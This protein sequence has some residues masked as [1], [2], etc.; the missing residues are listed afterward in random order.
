MDKRNF[1][2]PV[3]SV[4]KGDYVEFCHWFNQYESI[5]RQHQIAIWGA[6]IRGTEFAIFL[7]KKD[8]YDIVFVDS[9]SEKWGGTI[10]EFLII[11]PDELFNSDP[12]IKRKILIS[13]E[14][15]REIERKLE[16]KGLLNNEDFFVI[17]TFLYDKYMDEFKRQYMCKNLIMGDCE[18]S[19]I[20]IGDMDYRTLGEMIKE[21]CGEQNTKILAMHG[22]GLRAYYNIFQAQIDMGMLPEKLFLMVNFDTLTGKQHLLPRS[23][24]AELIKCVY[25]TT[26]C[27]R[28]ELKEYV[29]VVDKRSK[30]MDAEFFTASENKN[31][32]AESEAK[33]KN[34]FRL[35]YLFRLDVETEGIIY[36]KKIIDMALQSNITVLPFIPPVNYQL[37]EHLFGDKFRAKYESN[38]HKIKEITDSKTLKLLDFSY[39]LNSTEFAEPT[40]PD[41]TANEIGR[42]KLANGFYS[43]IMEQ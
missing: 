40:T 17:R 19:T 15:S 16:E 42:M 14:N 31:G 29:Q 43:E 30:M 10:D 25:E 5:L 38:V 20:A 37:G 36:L 4:D 12:K 6:G 28:E 26:P 39:L 21:H 22:M 9:N 18:F 24:H 1:A 11:S 2:W 7:K 13:T 32:H 35:N 33:I 23:Q 3:T 34:Y 27:K 8:F 41:E